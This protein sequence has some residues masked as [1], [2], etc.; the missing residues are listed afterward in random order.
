MP[1]INL[2]APSKKKGIFMFTMLI[3]AYI[4]FAINWVAGSNLSKQITEYYFNGQSVSASTSEL[5]NYTI[6]GARI[7]ANLLAVLI[8]AKLNPKNASLFALVLLSFSF[9]AVFS[10]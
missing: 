5:V 9:L 4:I 6:T 8:L 10:S 3:L 1:N 2:A 7:V